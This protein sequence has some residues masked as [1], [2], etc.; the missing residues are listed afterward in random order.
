[1]QM[2]RLVLS[3]RG[4]DMFGQKASGGDIPL[5]VDLLTQAVQSQGGTA[6][7]AAIQAA[8]G[9]SGEKRQK[10]VKQISG[11]DVVR[12]LDQFREQDPA[13]LD[14]AMRQA[15]VALGREPSERE[16]LSALLGSE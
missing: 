9:P 7:K 6:D 3:G 14:L 1:M 8:L 2:A 11:A 5:F 10:N 12:R 15:R 16:I 4:T 13:T